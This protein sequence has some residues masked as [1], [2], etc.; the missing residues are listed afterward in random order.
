MPADAPLPSSTP[1]EPAWIGRDTPDD[2]PVHGQQSPAP[3]LRT[4]FGLDGA[5]T[6]ATLT[7]AAGGYWQAW[8]NGERVGDQVLEPAPSQ[9]DRTVFSRTFDV[10]GSLRAGVNVLGVELGRGYFGMPDAV[11]DNF[12]YHRAP[13]RSEPRLWARLDLT[14]DDGGTR[15]VVSDGSWRMADGPTVDN[16]Y[17]GEAYDA[18][19]SL[20]G[21]TEAGFDDSA[22]AAAPEQPAPTEQ[23]VPATQPPVRVTE[24]L[25]PVEVTTLPGG[26]RL[27]DF[28]R[29]TAGWSRITVSGGTGTTVRLLHGQQLT[30]DGAV[31]Q[32]QADKDADRHVDSYTLGDGD[33]QVWEPSYTRHG[34]RYVQVSTS[35]PLESFEIEA[36]V[37]HSDL[38]STGSFA[39]SD[40]LLDAIHRNQRASLLSNLW[41]FP[42]DT[43]WR[44]RQGWLADAYLYLDSAALNFDVQGLYRDWL[45]TVRDAQRADGAIP[46]IAP[47]SREFIP[48]FDDPSW[49]GT[50]VLDVWLLYRYYGDRTFLTDN[51]ACLARW[52]DRMAA[53]VEGTGDLYTGFSFGDWASPGS[54]HAGF[55]APEASDLTANADLYTEA[56][57]LAAIARELGEG[58]DAARFDA[59]AD[60][61][62]TAFTAR[63]FR[64]DDGVYGTTGNAFTGAGDPP[65]RQTSNIVALAY[66][67]VPEEHRAAV[68]ANL[69]ADIRSRGTHLDTG[70][71]GT[72]LLLPLLTENGHAQLAHDLAV[73]T[74]YP[75]W[76]HWVEQGAT[77]SWE[78]WSVGDRDQ[79]LD[80]AFLGVADEWLYQYLAGIRPAA[81]GYAEVLVAPVVPDGLD[82]VSAAVETPHGR[83]AV[84]WVRSEGGLEITVELPAGVPAEVRVPDG[85]RAVSHRVT[86]GTHSFRRTRDRVG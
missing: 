38:A 47:D 64:P 17:L 41:G 27:V 59:L 34:F 70:T 4:A 42:T 16:L 29:V 58:G 32:F 13:W 52:M 80:H 86:G 18:R 57:T 11:G 37:V 39:S 31:Y 14:L 54:E 15:T 33:R 74:T 46:V 30:D 3:L 85:D 81:P 44:D 7:L 45:R 72:K 56:R 62:A 43:A 66:D 49:S 78:V 50:V 55:W 51:Y 22:W 9:Y 53:A 5:V 1:S 23:V 6:R 73:Q 28:G 77:T 12:E 2:W 40:P 10:S 8:V 75:S 83:V 61:I 35:A 82:S 71:I 20:A 36:R 63:F 25:A 76:G 65:Y 21:W 19:K 48:L 84:A 67:L 60:R 68:L 26:D 69:V 79:C 24:T